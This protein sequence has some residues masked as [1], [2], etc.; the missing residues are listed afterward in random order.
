MDNNNVKY[1]VVEGLA[2]ANP[3][4]NLK[5]TI[6]IAAI[7]D[8]FPFFP[9]NQIGHESLRH[10][11]RYNQKWKNLKRIASKIADKIC[12][13]NFI[14]DC[15]DFILTPYDN[16]FNKYSFDLLKHTIHGKYD[17]EFSGLHLISSFNKDVESV[18]QT[19]PEDSNGVW[20]ARI[21]LN[22][23]RRNKIYIKT[24]T[25]F[26]KDWTPS[27]FMFESFS[28]I[29]SINID[30]NVTEYSSITQSGIP[31]VIIIKNNRVKTIYPLYQGVK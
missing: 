9:K 20:E 13:D 10:L 11:R 22:N 19:K 24:S 4:K 29:K 17:K 16:E 31:V 27:H 2:N 12:D 23:K 30:S 28:A 5:S 25:F 3:S 7:P 1:Y 6:R 15:N 8:N 18:E 26:P 21:V 14:L